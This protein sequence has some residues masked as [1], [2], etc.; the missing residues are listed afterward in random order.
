MS[1][2]KV[3]KILLCLSILLIASCLSFY[4]YKYVNIQSPEFDNLISARIIGAN[5]SD[6]FV[7]M[8]WAVKNP[9]RL[10]YM[11]D[12]TDIYFYEFGEPIA[13]IF[14]EERISVNPFSSTNVR[15]I[16]TI[17][18]YN[19]ER[20]MYNFIAEYSFNIIGTAR[21]RVLFFPKT[22]RINQFIPINIKAMVNDFLQESFRNAITVERLHVRGT[23]LEF[24]LGFLNRTGLNLEISEFSG[25]VE[26]NRTVSSS[27]SVFEPVV[28][29]SNNPRLLTWL[30]FNFVNQAVFV[31][32]PL[33]Y[34]VSGMF[35]IR[36]WDG[37]YRI[38]VELVGEL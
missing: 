38:P 14:F 24:S 19:F 17:N 36:L 22:I 9:S 28:F 7:E 16:A 13:R 6:I 26:I 32:Q 3:N 12:D 34:V 4:V 30:R 21:A 23:Q 33:R 15:T 27:R 31:G 18:R 37:E 25:E 20:L 10:Y 2:K 29:D 35:I 11:I 8:T 5:E 1:Y